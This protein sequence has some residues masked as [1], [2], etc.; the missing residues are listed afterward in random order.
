M[1]LLQLNVALIDSWHTKV[2]LGPSNLKHL[3][4][5]PKSMSTSRLTRFLSCAPPFQ[6]LPNRGYAFKSDLHIKWVRPEK[7]HSTRPEKSGDLEPIAKIAPDS[8]RVD[9][10]D[11][12]E[13][14][15]ADEV[16]K[17]LFTLEFAPRNETI[18]A[19][20]EDMLG[21]VKRHPLDSESIEAKIALWTGTIRSLQVI[22]ILEQDC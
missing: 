19:Y 22:Y 7:I 4:R 9:F 8:L 3:S 15:T 12:E 14:K 10:R 2:R 1:D 5:R 6:L 16:V 11:S 18:K 17:K 21:R 20:K 13:L